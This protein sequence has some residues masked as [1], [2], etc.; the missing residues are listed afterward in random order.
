MRMG[1]T[2]L[3]LL[4]ALTVLLAAAACRS[5]PVDT[6]A[7][8]ISGNPRLL[9]AKCIDRQRDI[10]AWGNAERESM[11]GNTV[12]RFPGTNLIVGSSKARADY[13]HVQFKETKMIER[14]RAN[15]EAKAGMTIGE[16]SASDT[17]TDPKK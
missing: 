12:N 10:R 2:A 4:L 17:T 15:C 5:D 11:M 16:A 7:P 6:S 14:L 8:D 1:A 3:V 13:N 9:W